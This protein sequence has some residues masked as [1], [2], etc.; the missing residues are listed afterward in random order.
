MY[1]WKKL[2]SKVIF[3]HPRIT[4]V[5]D[6]VELPDRT[7]VPYLTYAR[8]NHAV[9]ILCTDGDTILLQQ[10]YAYPTGEVLYQFPGGKMEDEET[11]LQAAEREL[12]EEAGLKSGSI[13]E[14]GWYYMDPRRTD[15]KM[16]VFLATNCQET[17]AV[18]GDIEEDITSHWTP[19]ADVE[20]MIR[21]QEIVNFSVLSAWSVYLTSR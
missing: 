9:T 4:L 8:T 7:Q 5:E 12:K 21:N 18:G 14:L 20:Q 3:E 13:H 1:M 10:E 19:L 11:P 15:T 2:S 16:H 17:V 6:T